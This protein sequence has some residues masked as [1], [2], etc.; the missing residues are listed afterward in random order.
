MTTLHVAHALR[1]ELP[2]SDE[3]DEWDEALTLAT[4][5]YFEYELKRP[6]PSSARY[7]GVTA[8]YETHT[9]M[10]IPRSFLYTK[11]SL[12]EALEHCAYLADVVALPDT[13]M[14]NFERGYYD[15]TEKEHCVDQSTLLCPAVMNVPLPFQRGRPQ[16]QLVGALM[17]STDAKRLHRAYL[18]DGSDW[19]VATNGDQLK[20][21]DTCP[22]VTTGWVKYALEGYATATNG[23][24]PEYEYP[25]RLWYR[26]SA[27]LASCGTDD[28]RKEVA[29]IVAEA[30]RIIRNKQAADLEA[31][32]NEV[33]FDYNEDLDIKKK[34]NEVAQQLLRGATATMGPTDPHFVVQ[35][36]AKT[37]FAKWKEE[38]EQAKLELEKWQAEER[39]AWEREAKAKAQSKAENKARRATLNEAKRLA[40]IEKA[41]E[42]IRELNHQ[43]W[44]R[45][46]A[47]DARARAVVAE[48]RARLAKMNFCMRAKPAFERWERVSAPYREQAKLWREL[49]KQRAAE[50]LA[51]K[52]E[53]AEQALIAD[54]EERRLARLEREQAELEASLAES[55]PR[56]KQRNKQPGL[57]RTAKTPE[58]QARWEAERAA[59]KEKNR[60]LH[61]ER[62]LEGERRRAEAAKNRVKFRP[63]LD[64]KD[65]TLD[66]PRGSRRPV[67]DDARSVCSVASSAITTTTTTSLPSPSKHA[68]YRTRGYTRG[69]ND[70]PVRKHDLQDAKKNGTKERSA[71]G[72]VVHRGRHAT[73]VTDSTGQTAV[74]A[75]SER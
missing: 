58:E 33:R 40:E 71:N 3:D 60:L 56:L 15:N 23:V 69:A 20:E 25:L 2:H 46:A 52:R 67:D 9:A 31:K 34:R 17:A 24:F 11:F 28:E 45:R 68:R 42:R 10:A 50:E 18:L 35:T 22:K 73:L 37:D 30:G 27:K 7:R 6:V 29:C 70:R 47:A 14:I 55:G 62:R 75:W 12:P 4:K 51:A 44:A 65:W 41:K 63:M 38:R 5:N 59:I 61:E 13:M 64:L 1:L 26:A 16:Y 48:N 66:E 53:Q 74:T 72:N 36:R 57:D 8:A 39:A 54:T 21:L 49:E 43:A 19:R 32:R